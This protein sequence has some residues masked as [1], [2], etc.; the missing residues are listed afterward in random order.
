MRH[1]LG[2][3]FWPVVLV[4][5]LSACED[6]KPPSNTGGSGG[7]GGSGGAPA[8]DSGKADV[9]SPGG[10]GGTGGGASDGGT[11]DTATPPDGG[12]VPC[13]LGRPGDLDRPPS[14]Q[15]PCDLL[16]PGFVAP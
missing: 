4:A 10:S 5:L 1:G 15:L 12:L 11:I 16:P 13:L 8:Q 14:G 6:D 3:R 9:P 7:S 2:F